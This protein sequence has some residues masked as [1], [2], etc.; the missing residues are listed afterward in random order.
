MSVVRPDGIYYFDES[1]ALDHY[2]E[3]GVVEER[4]IPWYVETNTQGANRAH[5]AMAHLQ[6][7]NLTVGNFRGV[8]RYG[9][10]GRDVNG[11]P[12]DISKLLHD[13]GAVSADGTTFDLESYLR[14]AKGMK[15]WFFY[16]GSVTE[17]NEVQ[18]STGQLSLVQYRYTPLTVNTGYDY[19]SV[20]T[21][22]Y[23]RGGNLATDRTSDD[24]VPYP[25]ID[26]GRP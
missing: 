10:R 17:D 25:M 12:V 3:A 6:Q 5:D 21:F 15:E 23:G 2:V 20:E 22:E 9:I 1:S 16:A 11:K 13:S 14:I 7:A 4:S 24:G 26:T 8:M 18:F 19:G